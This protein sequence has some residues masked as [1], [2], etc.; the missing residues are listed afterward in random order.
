MAGELDPVADALLSD[1]AANDVA[2]LTI[3]QVAAGVPMAERA[4]EAVEGLDSTPFGYLPGEASGL[5]ALGLCLDRGCDTLAGLQLNQS[6]QAALDDVG[7]IVILAADRDSLAGW[8]EQVG[9]QTDIEIIGGVTQAMGPIAGPY[10]VSGQLAGL[11][12]GLPVSVA[13]GQ[14]AGEADGPGDEQLASLTLAQ[15]LAIIA[16]LASIIYFG[17]VEPAASAVG[18]V[19]KK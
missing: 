5:R 17:F 14:A 12:E 8:L 3:S 13:Y 4:S 15:W 9:T 1:L 7:L 11:V 2:V 10:V 16:F 19:A 18:E 6:W